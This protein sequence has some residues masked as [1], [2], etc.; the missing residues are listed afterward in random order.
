MRR[1]RRAGSPALKK[2]GTIAQQG[3]D[4]ANRDLSEASADYERALAAQTGARDQLTQRIAGLR[5]AK[6]EQEKAQ[7]DLQQTVVRAPFDGQVVPFSTKT[8]QYLNAGDVVMVLVSDDGYRIV[9]NIHEQHLQYIRAG[10][11][12]H[13]TVATAPWVVFKGTVRGISKGISRN[14]T[15]TPALPYVDPETDWIRLS[16]RFPVEINLSVEPDERQ[17]FMGADARVLIWNTSGGEPAK[18]AAKAGQ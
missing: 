5:E 17:T 15:Q 3:L 7:Y 1:K 12:V 9:A 11:P 16:R 8:G 18:T 6:A 2:S 14:I 13:Y 4:D 10:Q